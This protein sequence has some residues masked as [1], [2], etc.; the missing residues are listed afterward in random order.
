VVLPAGIA[1]VFAM[2]AGCCADDKHYIFAHDHSRRHQ[3]SGRE[4]HAG[5]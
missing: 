1:L 2:R 3:N 5:A 4:Q